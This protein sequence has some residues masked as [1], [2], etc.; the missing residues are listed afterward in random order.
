MRRACFMLEAGTFAFWCYD[1][2][3]SASL[4]SEKLK[5]RLSTGIFTCWLAS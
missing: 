3:S 1:S 4:Y 5:K 2:G